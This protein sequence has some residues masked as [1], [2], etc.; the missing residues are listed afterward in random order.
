VGPGSQ[1]KLEK[2]G[3]YDTAHIM[4]ESYKDFGQQTGQRF[5]LL[6]LQ[7]LPQVQRDQ[8][9]RHGVDGASA[10]SGIDDKDYAA[11]MENVGAAAKGFM[12]IFGS[13][14]VP[15][16]IGGL[17]ILT[18]AMHSLTNLA[19]AH[20]DVDKTGLGAMFGRALLGNF[21]RAV[22]DMI[23]HLNPGSGVPTAPP[24]HGL[25]S[26]HG[27]GDLIP[28]R[29]PSTSKPLSCSTAKCSPRLCRG[30]WGRPRNSRIKRRALTRAL[31][32]LI[33]PTLRGWVAAK[34]FDANI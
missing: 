2:E 14:S 31:H 8:L 19:A 21:V 13:P 22:R 32:S 27:K 18:E 15:N 24:I 4:A 7:N 16:A 34:V 17:H 11:K 10:Y 9:L 1:G 26:T 5:G 20:P 28:P 29:R 33:R 12:E 6:F 25:P 30:K 23:N 3:T